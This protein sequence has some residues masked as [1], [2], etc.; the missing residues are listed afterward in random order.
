MK[1]IFTIRQWALLSVLTTSLSI[2]IAQD[3]KKVDEAVVAESNA[4]EAVAAQQPSMVEPLADPVIPV[5]LNINLLQGMLQGRKIN[6]IS[7][8][9]G[10]E[11]YQVNIEGGVVYLSKDGR[12]LLQGQ[13]FDLVKR[14]DL[15]EQ[16]YGQQRAKLIKTVDSDSMIV[17]RAPNEKYVVNI[18]TDIDCQ[19]CR[20]LHSEMQSYLDAGITVRYLAFPRT[21][22]G[23]PSANKAIQVWCSD[24]K[25]TAMTEAKLGQELTSPLCPKNPVADHFNLGVKMNINGTPAILLEDGTLIPGYVAADTLLQQLSAHKQ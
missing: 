4:T 2:S 25:Q 10:T 8:I 1:L 22:M 13:L 19:Y 20:K 7:P 6:E 3:I 23:T 5:G 11:W 16:Y 21:G 24:N 18:F 12:Y 17:Y 9:Q 15:T 14:E